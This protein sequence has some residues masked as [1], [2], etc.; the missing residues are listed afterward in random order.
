MPEYIPTRRFDR[1]LSF[2]SQT[3]SPPARLLDLG[4][5]NRLA[6]EFRS[7]GFSVD[8]TGGE[9]LDLDPSAVRKDG[10]DCVTAFEII[11]HLVCPMNVLSSIKAERLFATIPMRLWFAS[12]YRNDSDPRDR[13]YHE[14]EDWQFDWLLEKSGWSIVRREKWTS[15]AG[16][17]GVR[18]LLRRVTPRYYAV[19][20]TRIA[21]SS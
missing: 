3:L 11:E 13:H 9:D 8:N 18:P 10:Y 16:L 14:F 12:A 15:P 19:E 2:V 6:G 7:A 20:A 21:T 17:I 1:T 5:D 4:V